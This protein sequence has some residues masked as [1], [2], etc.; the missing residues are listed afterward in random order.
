MQ[1]CDRAPASG[2]HPLSLRRRA[3]GVRIASG[4]PAIHPSSRRGYRKRRPLRRSSTSLC[5]RRPRFGG[6]CNV[7]SLHPLR[8]DLG[9]RRAGESGKRFMEPNHLGAVSEIRYLHRGQRAA[10]HHTMPRQRKVRAGIQGRSRTSLSIRQRQPIQTAD[11]FSMRR[12]ARFEAIGAIHS[13]LTDGH[14]FLD[15][16]EQLREL[17]RTLLDQFR[18]QPWGDKHARNVTKDL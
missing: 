7:L 3:Q 14:R 15:L 18:M 5:I 8:L 9:I 12:Q 1:R 6:L 16:L 13:H 17:A 2:L 11:I 10:E 4:V